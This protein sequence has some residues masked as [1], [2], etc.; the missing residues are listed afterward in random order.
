MKMQAVIYLR[1]AQVNDQAISFQR[2][3]CMRTAEALGATVEDAYVDNG[4][5]G[6][7]LD[8]PRLQAMLQ[9]L[10]ERGDID[11]V[12]TYAPDRLSRRPSDNVPLSAEIEQTGARMVF[13][14]GTDDVP[15]GDL[16]QSI[17]GALWRA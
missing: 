9:S 17:R 2:E 4:A 14:D 13:A 16:M 1:T 12:I 8:R 7:N 6:M 5:S 10:K 15:S 11:Y 3:A